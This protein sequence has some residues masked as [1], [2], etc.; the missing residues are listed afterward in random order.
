MYN[1][2]FGLERAPFRITPD[3]KLFYPGGNRGEILEALIYAIS[4]GEGIVKVVGEVGSGKTMLCRMLEER[5]ADSVDIVYLANPSLSPEDTLH[6]IALEMKLDV[7]PDANRLQV[8]HA[9]QERLLEKADRDDLK[10]LEERLMAGQNQHGDASG[11]GG[12]RG[13]SRRKAGGTKSGMRRSGGLGGRSGAGGVLEGADEEE[14]PQEM[15]PEERAA[16]LARLQSL[17]EQRLANLQSINEH[18]GWGVRDQHVREFE[19]RYLSQLLETHQGNVKAAAEQAQLPRGTLYRLMKNH[20][21]D[22][23][24]YR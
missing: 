11:D 20:N 6:A 14:P 24:D 18:R 4:S 19:A 21:I 3:T 8:M 9:L 5:L 17:L 23:A 2:H 16:E 15:T 13:K 12:K 1:E 22:G 7:E 10:E